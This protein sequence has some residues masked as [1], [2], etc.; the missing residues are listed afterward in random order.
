M[1]AVPTGKQVSVLPHSGLVNAISFSSD[2][3]YVGTGN[4]DFSG[5]VFDTASGKLV[6]RLPQ[7]HTVN[8]VIFSS[9]GF[10]IATAGGD[11]TA[12][13]FQ[14]ESG[15]EVLRLMHPLSVNTIDFSPDG[16]YLATGDN[17][18]YVRLFSTASENFVLALHQGWVRSISPYGKTAVVVNG[19]APGP[20]R[21][22]DL[23]SLEE[24]GQLRVPDHL[25]AIGMTPDGR[26]VAS[27]RWEKQVD[28]TLSDTQNRSERLLESQ[29][30]AARVDMLAFSPDKRLL[31]VASED[32]TARIFDVETGRQVAGYPH[33]DNVVAVAFTPDGRYLVSGCWD[34]RARFF[35]LASGKTSETLRLDSPDHAT[36]WRIFFSHDGDYMLTKSDVAYVWEIDTHKSGE[37]R[38]LNK[39][40]A[41]PQRAAGDVSAVAFSLDGKYVA[42][43]NTD[44]TVRVYQLPSGQEVSRLSHLGSIAALEFSADGASIVVT[45]TESAQHEVAINQY[46]L[47][48]A[49]L[50][51]EACARLDR[52]LTKDEW[53]QYMLSGRWHKT[54]SDL[55]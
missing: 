36:V 49:N 45:S 48:T 1:I 50:V 35:D 31:A 52:N 39:P 41:L 43:G 46:D 13:I 54:C 44:E 47:R 18:H 25:T 34:H 10:N 27:A 26:Y 23:S 11:G 16:R 30:A 40:I 12:R 28:V 21:V 22:V 4:W 8:S 5:R 14:L 20:G 29:S 2:G 53:K 24:V 6:L 3:R 33:P 32:R 7:H 51:R 37:V 19:S 17:D 15:R 55:P 9:D 38:L 42:T